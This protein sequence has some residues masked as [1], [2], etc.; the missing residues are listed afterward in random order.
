MGRYGGEEFIIFFYDTDEEIGLKI[1]ERLRNCFSESPVPLPKG[2]VTIHASFGLAVT[3]IKKSTEK[4]YIQELIHD[5]DT[6]L[7]AAK[8]SG[9]N[10]VVLFSPEMESRQDPSYHLSLE[11]A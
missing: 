3:D 2:P 9:R 4:E 8:L 1:L 5:A 7:Y 10:K 11:K 6:A